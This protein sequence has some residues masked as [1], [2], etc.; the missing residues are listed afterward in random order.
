MGAYLPFQFD[1]NLNRYFLETAVLSLPRVSP[2][3]VDKMISEPYYTSRGTLTTHAVSISYF[4]SL[5][6]SVSADHVSVPEYVQKLLTIVS[7]CF[8]VACIG[9][10]IGLFCATGRLEDMLLRHPEFAL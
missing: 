9:H 4:L 8:Y 10:S 1:Q 6:F 3:L 7:L 2:D 5:E